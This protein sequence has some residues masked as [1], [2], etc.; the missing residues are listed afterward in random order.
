ML[1]I[2]NIICNFYR[3]HEPI[4][5][6]ETQNLYTK[7]KQKLFYACDNSPILDIQPRPA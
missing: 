3:W 5:N 7:R 1:N 6:V 4:L 2:N